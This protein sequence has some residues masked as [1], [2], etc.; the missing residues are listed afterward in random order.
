MGGRTPNKVGKS[1][2]CSWLLSAWKFLIERSDLPLFCIIC[3]GQILEFRIRSFQ[4][5]A[6]PDVVAKFERPETL[7]KR[8][9]IRFCTFSNKGI[10]L[11]SGRTLGRPQHCY[12]VYF[13]GL[14]IISLSLQ[15]S[16]SAAYI[17]A[18]WF[19]ALQRQLLDAH[20]KQPRTSRTL[21]QIK[22][23]PHLRVF[24]Q[25]GDASVLDTIGR[26]T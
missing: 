1:H 21:P 11:K 8:E 25:G 17:F 5:I 2:V 14:C 23:A 22:L 15:W 18:S 10:L 24:K 6:T 3:H 26:P 20:E 19:S 9:R 12:Q 4:R 7:E 16:K 13:T